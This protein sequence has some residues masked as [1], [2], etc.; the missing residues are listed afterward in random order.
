MTIHIALDETSRNR[1]K[2]QLQIRA[3]PS[4]VQNYSGLKTLS[5]LWTVFPVQHDGCI[6]KKHLKRVLLFVP[7]SVSCCSLHTICSSVLGVVAPLKITAPFC[8]TVVPLSPAYV[9]QQRSLLN[10][11]KNGVKYDKSTCLHYQ[12]KYE[13]EVRHAVSFL[14]HLDDEAPL[15]SSASVELFV[16]TERASW[17]S[18]AKEGWKYT[19][20]T[21]ELSWC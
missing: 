18:V 12:L 2:L 19:D 6:V 17:S 14:S 1:V 8:Y 9:L 13:I 11:Q 10:S 5:M 15:K 3:E 16:E 20:P 4:E 21:E 7:S